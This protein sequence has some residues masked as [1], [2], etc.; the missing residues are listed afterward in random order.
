MVPLQLTPRKPPGARVPPAFL[1]L[2]KQFGAVFFVEGA[3]TVDGQNPA[4]PEKPWNTIQ[5]NS[6]FTMVS[7]WCEMDFVHPH[8]SPTWGVCPDRLWSG[9]RFGVGTATRGLREVRAVG[10]E[11]GLGNKDRW[12]FFFASTCAFR[13][14]HVRVEFYAVGC[15]LFF[16]NI[17]FGWLKG[18]TNGNAALEGPNSGHIPKWTSGGRVIIRTPHRPNGFL[19]RPGLGPVLETPERRPPKRPGWVL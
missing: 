4:P 8:I 10:V 9:S 17:E 2:P 14:R 6:G 11:T 16:L 7:K 13:R 19:L 5:I 12:S 15:V 1:S 3:H 18:A